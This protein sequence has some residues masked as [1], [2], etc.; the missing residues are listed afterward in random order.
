ML[1]PNGEGA[2]PMGVVMGT[3]Y[4]E[5]THHA[6]LIGAALL[7]ALPA[8]AVPTSVTVTG[9]GPCDPL[10]VPSTVDELGLAPPFPAGEQIAASTGG[11]GFQ[12]CPASPAGPGDVL[13]FILNQT[14]IAFKDL[15][16]VANPGTTFTNVDGYISGQP[17]FKIDTVGI[18]KPLVSED[19]SADGIFD[20][21]ETWTFVIQ[22]YQNVCGFDP[23]HLES[24]GVPDAMCA[25]AGSIIATPVPEPASAALLG[26]GLLGL[27]SW[28]RARA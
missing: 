12:V 5:W 21:G 13:V 4:S 9:Q 10:S 7:I 6:A 22:G 11:S 3:L 24:I 25:A 20:P 2:H 28:R 1:S 18:H 8:A 16:Y 15:W 23:S 14:S 26:I 17:A 27:V 19:M